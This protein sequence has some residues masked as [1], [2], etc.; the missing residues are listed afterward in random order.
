MENFLIAQVRSK[1]QALLAENLL[2][3]VSHNHEYQ[4]IQLFG[5]LLLVFD[6]KFFLQPGTEPETQWPS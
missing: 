4:F 3:I 5:Y 1:P 6:H 2:L